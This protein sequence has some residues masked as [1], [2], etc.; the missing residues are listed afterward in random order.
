[1]QMNCQFESSA[2]FIITNGKNLNLFINH[3]FK[4]AH[5]ITPVVKTPFELTLFGIR[6]SVRI[7]SVFNG[8][9]MMDMQVKTRHITIESGNI[10]SNVFV[11]MYYQIHHQRHT[12]FKVLYSA[13]YYD[14][15]HWKLC[16]VKTVCIHMS[17]RPF[18]AAPIGIVVPH[19]FSL[20]HIN[21]I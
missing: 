13:F 7:W 20:S 12:G 4:S 11:T 15:N 3:L 21:Q 6:K 18:K 1:M 5:R 8:L 14:I 19:D 2:M 16:S 10:T 17:K 9:V